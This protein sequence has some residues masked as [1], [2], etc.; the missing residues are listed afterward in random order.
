MKK[1]FIR[2]CFLIILMSPMVASSQ[3]KAFISVG[4]ELS[5]PAGSYTE[6]GNMG[7]GG[8][9]RFEHPWSK[10]VSGILSIEYVQYN[11]REINPYFHEQFSALPIQFGVKYYLKEKAIYPEGFYFSGETGFTGEFYH[12][13]FSGYNN[14]IDSHHDTYIGFCSTL[15]AGYQLGIMDLGFRFQTLLSTNS[16][17]TSYYSFRLAVSIR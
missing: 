3:K 11:T 8:S 7:I 13:T 9:V 12:L 14:A 10:H 17:I 16:G 2:I 5:F 4:A 1:K 6:V 15:G